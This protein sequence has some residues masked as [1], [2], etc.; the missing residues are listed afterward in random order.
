M[1]LFASGN[2]PTIGKVLVQKQPDSEQTTFSEG[3]L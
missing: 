1:S 2:F 3:L